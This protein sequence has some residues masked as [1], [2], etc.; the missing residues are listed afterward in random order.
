MS[1]LDQHQRD[2]VSAPVGA[3]RQPRTRITADKPRRAEEPAASAAAVDDKAGQPPTSRATDHPSSRCPASWI[4]AA[5]A[6]IAAARET[7]AWSPV[8]RRRDRLDVRIEAELVGS[9]IAPPTAVAGHD[10]DR[11]KQALVS[12]AVPVGR[13]RGQHPSGGDVEDQRALAG[14]VT[15]A[16]PPALRCSSPRCRAPGPAGGD[17]LSHALGGARTT[18]PARRLQSDKRRLRPART[19]A[20]PTGDDGREEHRSQTAKH[21]A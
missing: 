7:A 16:I 14:G 3:G 6:A 11:C 8:C 4:A 17:E 1:L 18:S 19:I 5:P 9:A 21:H 15:C 2:E 10:E 12:Q 13:G 20:Q